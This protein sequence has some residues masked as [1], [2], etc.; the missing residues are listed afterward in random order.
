M[1]LLSMLQDD[2][3]KLSALRQGLISAGAAMMAGGRQ[4]F[5]TALGQGVGAGVK[6]YAEKFE[7]ARKKA[8]AMAP[9]K[10]A[11]TP[12][13]PAVPAVYKVGGQS[14]PQLG[15]AQEVAQNMYNLPVANPYLPPREQPKGETYSGSGIDEALGMPASLMPQGL[16]IEDFSGGQPGQIEEVA[17]QPATPESFDVDKYFQAG[18]ANPESDLFKESIKYFASKQLEAQKAKNPTEKFGKIMPHSF[19]PESLAQ[20]QQTGNY[21]DLKPIA[22]GR[23]FGKVNPGQ[24]TPESLA[25]YAETGQYGDLVPFRSPVQIDQG[26]VK[27]LYHPGSRKTES[28]GVAPKPDEMPAFKAAQAAAVDSAKIGVERASEKP[29]AASRVAAADAKYKNL[30]SAIEKAK[31]QTGYAS[32][33]IAAQLTSGIGYTPA[34]NLESTLETVK[35]NLGFDELQEMRDN[36]PTGGALGQVAV[37]EIQYLQS[38]LASLK[39]K[40]TPGQLRENLDKIAAAKKASNERIKAAYEATYGTGAATPPKDLPKK[41]VTHPKYPGF[42][43][44]K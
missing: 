1:G 38:V 27:T 3:E 21:A 12:A 30:L 13:K 6:T 4:D 31:S 25:R 2:P 11:M 20:Y 40:Q 41:P 34:A 24:F 35:A 15:Q 19:T 23:D 17:A 36:S 14:L 26:N 33:G 16:G 43:I 29:K 32:T 44:V 39:Q 18:L 37:Q 8:L 42:S 22:G 28:Y 10:A 7:E 5:G 9:Y